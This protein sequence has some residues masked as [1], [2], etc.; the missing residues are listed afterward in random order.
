MIITL[1][2]RFGSITLYSLHFWNQFFAYFLDRSFSEATAIDSF[3]FALP[4]QSKK[5]QLLLLHYNYMWRNT[6]KKLLFKLQNR[7]K[8]RSKG[9]K[10]NKYT[11]ID[12]SDATEIV[13]KLFSIIDNASDKI[14]R[15]TCY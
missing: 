8:K 10:S 2:L 3:L 14:N 13:I 4:F 11:K 1:I 9:I 15:V 12:D 5:D 6:E 7:Y